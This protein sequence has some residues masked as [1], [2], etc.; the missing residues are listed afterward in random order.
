VQGFSPSLAYLDPSTGAMIVSAIVAVFA[1]LILGF[2]T[3]W[4]KIAGLFK[5]RRSPAAPKQSVEDAVEKAAS[6][7]DRPS[8]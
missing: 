7:A 2:K 3:C 4:Y 5:R 6:P 8:D 1:T